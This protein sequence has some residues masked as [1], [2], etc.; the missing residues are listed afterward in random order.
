MAGQQNYKKMDTSNLCK[1]DDGFSPL[2]Q[3]EKMGT[4]GGVYKGPILP[5]IWLQFLLEQ[6]E[7]RKD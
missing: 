5:H 2:S 3:E 4:Y 1:S 7:K 6:L